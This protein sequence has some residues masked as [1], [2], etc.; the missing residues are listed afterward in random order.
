MNLRKRCTYRGYYT[1][2][3]YKVFHSFGGRL[4][5][6]LFLE[7]S[8]YTQLK[9]VCFVTVLAHYTAILYGVFG[10]VVVRPSVTDV[11]WLTVRASRL[12]VKLLHYNN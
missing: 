2:S 8:S 12:I 6:L 1:L 9:A 10:I 3:F 11:L 4:L 7:E 5:L